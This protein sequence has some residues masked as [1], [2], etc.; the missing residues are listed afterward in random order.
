MDGRGK[1]SCLG[2]AGSYSHLAAQTL[3]P[4]SE[5]LLLRSFPAVFRALV[6]G[7]AEDAVIPIENSI[8]GG[9]LENLDLLS[10]EDVFAIEQIMLRIDHR[11]ATRP[12]VAYQNIRRVYSHEQAIGQCSA[13]LQRYLP[14]AECIFTDST[15]KSLELVDDESAGIV[16]SHADA[17]G[18][19][20]S[21]ENIANEKNN[22]TQFFRLRRREEGLPAHSRTVFFC[23]VCE[24]RPGSLLELLQA[25]SQR[26]INLTRI[27]S[28]PIRGV[29]G[30]YRF[31]I[32]I[33]GDLAD[34][35]IVL[36]LR[37]TRAH[38]R[39]FRL[40]GAYD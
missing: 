29:L 19:E 11:L 32:E 8:Q 14:Q 9:V 21:K 23:A 15:A 2:P 33:E 3:C 27:E 36:A 16:G 24:H 4:H 7:E 22:F 12:G 13:F 37:A 40:L 26:N 20:L 39:Q 31:Y 35:A 30:E 18:L 1:V 6:S 25:F 28:R 34:E 5:P 38:C 10:A 17:A